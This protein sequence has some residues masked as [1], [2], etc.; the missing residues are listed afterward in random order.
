MITSFKVTPQLSIWKESIQGLKDNPVCAV[1]FYHDTYELLSGIA[2]DNNNAALLRLAKLVSFAARTLS[3][4]NDLPKEA[5]YRERV[6]YT[7]FLDRYEEIFRGV[8]EV[9]QSDISNNFNIVKDTL[10]PVRPSDI[11]QFHFDNTDEEAQASGLLYMASRCQDPTDRETIEEIQKHY[12]NLPQQR[13]LQFLTAFFK[14]E[15]AFKW[16]QDVYISLLLHNT[17]T[18]EQRIH[19][20]KVI[21]E[22]NCCFL[23]TTNMR[24]EAEADHDPTFKRRVTVRDKII[25]IN[26]HCLEVT[27]VQCRSAQ[28]AAHVLS[29]LGHLMNEPIFLEDE[30]KV[31]DF[32]QL[33]SGSESGW[34]SYL[35]DTMMYS[36]SA[37][38]GKAAS[39]YIERVIEYHSRTG[40]YPLLESFSAYEN[41]GPEEYARS[42][43]N[44]RPHPISHFL[45]SYGLLRSPATALVVLEEIDRNR[46]WEN[47]PDGKNEF[48]TVLD[49]GNRFNHY[50][51][52]IP[53]CFSYRLAEIIE[54]L[55]T[56][57]ESA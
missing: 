9:Y 25:A 24:H 41:L 34:I 38:G 50:R 16:S 46:L 56:R 31:L 29:S 23:A 2:H 7:Y 43:D 36:I 57:L 52:T 48:K 27:L 45:F 30:K 8:L 5:L 12:S 10:G 54:A 1:D 14:S 21:L 20:M 55:K 35:L 32:Y 11:E 26:T 17:M 4:P 33:S 51:R 42:W 39:L 28:E 44:E 22:H 53:P 19:L 18:L 15:D 3:E 6:A 13:Q 47:L 49:N 37:T 40:K